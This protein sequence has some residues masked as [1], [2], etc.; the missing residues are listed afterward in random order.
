MYPLTEKCPKALL[1][2]ANRPVIDYCLDLLE[3]A[4]FSGAERPVAMPVVE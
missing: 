4:G 1:P 2:V 3:K